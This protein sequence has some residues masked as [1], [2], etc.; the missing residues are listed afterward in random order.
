MKQKTLSILISIMTS[1]LFLQAQEIS[2]DAARQTAASFIKS[3]ASKLPHKNRKGIIKTSLKSGQLHLVHTKM[4]KEHNSPTLY[5]F[6]AEQGGYVI[7]S[8]DER[9]YPVLGYSEDGAF[10]TDSMNCCMKYIL[11]EYSRQITEAREKN[12]PRYEQAAEDNTRQNIEPLLTCQWNRR[13]PFNNLYPTYSNGERCIAGNQGTAMAQIMYYYKW[14]NQG[15]GSRTYYW[16]IGKKDI[17]A[18]FENTTYRWDLMKDIYDNESDD[19]EDAVATLMYHCAVACGTQFTPTGSSEALGCTISTDPF[20]YFNYSSSMSFIGTSNLKDQAYYEIMHRRPVLVYG[21]G[22]SYSLI[23]VCDGYRADG[24]FHFNLG[25][26]SYPNNYFQFN[27]I[28]YGSY[29]YSPYELIAKILPKNLEITDVFGNIYAPSGEEACLLKG[30]EIKLRV[31]NIPSKVTTSSGISYPVTEISPNA[32][33]GCWQISSITIPNTVRSIGSCAFKSCGCTSITIPNSVTSI[34]SYAFSWSSL[35]KISIPNSVTT[36]GN[37][38]FEKCTGLKDIT[39]P[40]SLTNIGKYVFKECTGL[41]SIT[42]PNSVATIG[43]YAFQKCTGL[44][45]ITIPNSVTS[46]GTGAFRECSGLTN[47]T[48]PNSVNNIGN[49]VF[50]NCDNLTDIYMLNDTPPSIGENAFPDQA[51]LQ[52][53]SPKLKAAEICTVHIPAGSRS[54]YEAAGYDIYRLVE[55]DLTDIEPIEISKEKAN[56]TYYN[57]QGRRIRQP[58]RGQLVIARYSDGTSRKVLV[59]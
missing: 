51:R 41:T 33:E 16:Q 52:S 30:L 7:A 6:E 14:P 35:S 12:L 26:G 43:D 9:A 28:S 58:Q 21:L 38:A 24:F 23:C 15:V 57:L 53:S 1:V 50:Y 22:S 48:I 3:H 47:I 18:D 40:N 5:V 2:V 55:E 4:D 31:L 39:L 13:E 25:R 44:K 59:K 29:G 56:A 11:E 54:A 37:Y 45:N 20:Q 17:S 27:S 36:I 46:I 10:S 32:L 19:P 34:G 8:A 49:Q 42:I